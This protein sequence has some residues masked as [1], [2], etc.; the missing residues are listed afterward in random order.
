MEIQTET[1]KIETDRL[2][3]FTESS[4]QSKSNEF[5]QHY[6]GLPNFNVVI[7]IFDFMVSEQ[8]H[9]GTKLTAF[10]EFMVA[11]LKLRHNLSSQ[12]LAYCFD[13]HALSGVYYYGL[14]R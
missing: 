12:N 5:I 10:Q 6:T 4:L 9:G 3:P 14:F 7:T 1:L 8:S 13:V 2:K 11:L